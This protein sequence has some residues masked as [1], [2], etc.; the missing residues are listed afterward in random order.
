MSNGRTGE[1]YADA[2]HVVGPRGSSKDRAPSSASHLTNH[3]YQQRHTAPRHQT[4]LGSATVTRDASRRQHGAKRHLGYASVD[5]GYLAPPHSQTNQTSFN[6]RSGRPTAGMMEI[7]R[8]RTRRERTFIGS[9]CAVCEEPLE[10]TLRGERI[11]QFSCGHVSHEACF[12]E[13]IKEFDSQYCPTCNAPLG[14]DTSRGG[15][16]L[17]LGKW[18]SRHAEREELTETEKLSNIVRSVDG[19]DAGNRSSQHTPTPWDQQPGDRPSSR[20]S[21]GRY[22][23]SKDSR[24]YSNRDS[25]ENNTR[26]RIE[27]YGSTLSV[28]TRDTQGTHHRQNS[29]GTG[30]MS[31]GPYDEA[32]ATRKH[33]YD[34]TAMESDLHS[35]R[36]GSMTKNPI[37]PPVV[38]VRSEYPTLTRSKHSQVVTCLVTVEVPEGKWVPDPDDIRSAPPVHHAPHP[39]KEVISGPRRG[40][41]DRVG[42]STESREELD[43]ITEDLHARVDN[44]HGLDFARYVAYRT[45][46]TRSG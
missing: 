42:W 29:Q 30:Y 36:V 39:E 7:E 22:R 21:V 8:Q 1:R 23:D 11:L 13:Y 24:G 4:E 17:D 38:T 43:E 27:R 6:W 26:Q 9:E 5:R 19:R 41:E 44:W 28:R 12:Y 20:G 15:N 33:D 18:R 14:L 31:Q 45:A 34:L 3:E 40:S 46:R 37:P 2:R 25:G 16:V 32:L 35:P 10:H